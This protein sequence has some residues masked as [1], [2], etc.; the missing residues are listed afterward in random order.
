MYGN[1][2]LNLTALSWLHAEARIGLNVLGR[3]FQRGTWGYLACLEGGWL[4]LLLEG[5]GEFNLSLQ[6]QIR[7]LH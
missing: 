5:P 4:T 3:T 6:G 1:T 7:P 2:S